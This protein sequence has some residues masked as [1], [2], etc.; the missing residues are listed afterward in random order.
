MKGK[1]WIL[2]LIG[3]IVC[4][5]AAAYLFADY[6]RQAADTERAMNDLR[7]IRDQ[8]RNERLTQ[9][10]DDQE[11]AQTDAPVEDQEMQSEAPVNVTPLPVATPT[12]E[13]TEAAAAEQTP[14][15]ELTTA[16]PTESPTPEPTLEPSPTPFVFREDLILAEYRELYEMNS[17]LIGWLTIEGT[18]I[19]YPVVQSIDPDYYL[20]HD[21]YGNKNS[22][23]MLIMDE[24]CDV[25][26]PSPSIL[27]H[28]HNM[29]N[30]KMFKDLLKYANESFGKE[31][32]TIQFD[33]LVDKRQ[34]QVVAAFYSKL[35]DEEK[36]EEG[37]RYY[38][39]VQDL[40]SMAYFINGIRT[41]R[42]Y[43]TGVE[44]GANDEYIV[45][46]TCS[47]HVTDGRFVVVAKRVK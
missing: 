13:G 17:D 10:P 47:Y 11:T 45:L 33:T 23:G 19:D 8:A 24:H 34:Y 30:G 22:N 16:Q 5:L 2:F 25:Y 44:F 37:F 32:L 40:N 41:E 42:R 31:H 29:K 9:T 3:G 6:M 38:V 35:Y 39:N 14:E 18:V 15:V 26:K 7:E 20:T 28:G 21:F 36:G 4:A 43:D 27:I 12:A 46:S 1:T